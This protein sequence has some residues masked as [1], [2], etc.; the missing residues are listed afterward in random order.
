MILQ[1][2]RLTLRPWAEQDVDTLA[3]IANDREIWRNVRDTFPHPYTREA[4]KGWVKFCQSANEP[5]PFAIEFQ[6]RLIGGIGLHPFDDVHRHSAELGYW[7]AKSH[8]G[9]GI[10]TEAVRKIVEYGFQ[11]LNLERIQAGIYDWNDAS[12]RVLLKAGFECEGRMRHH[13]F[14]DG[15]FVDMMLYAR[16]RSAPII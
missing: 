13:A 10:A 1:T 8:W 7:L 12:G 11:N 3:E 2:E 14:K 15:Q 16:I 6:G 4:A 9:Q 5:H